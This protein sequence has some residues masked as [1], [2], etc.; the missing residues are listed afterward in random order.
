V[1]V[2]ISCGSPINERVLVNVIADVDP[3]SGVEV[4]VCVI[5]GVPAEF[6][7]NT[8]VPAL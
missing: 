4:S 2:A 1:F 8:I 6:Q 3:I 7:V 5:K